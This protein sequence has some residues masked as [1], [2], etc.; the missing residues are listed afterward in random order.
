MLRTR[1]V[2][3]KGIIIN[4]VALL[5]GFTIWRVLFNNYAREVFDISAAEIGIIQAVREVP[6]LLGFTV[7][8]IALALSEVHIVTLSIAITGAGLVV[9]GLANSIL[10]LGAGT[11]LMSV[12]FHNVMTA[13]YS[14]LLLFV[15][16]PESGRKQGEL[17][18]WE[19]VAAVSA[20]FLVFLTSLT[21]GYR[22]I[23]ISTGLA[24]IVAGI[25][26]TLLYT[27]NRVGGEARSFRVD[28]RYW[29]YY[30]IS[31]L[32]GCRRHI[33]TTFAIFLMVANHGLRI[34]YTALLFLATSTLTIYTNRKF[35]SVTEILGERRVLVYTS[36]M[37]V[38]IFTGYAFITEINLLIGLF[39]I[40]N[41]LFGSG[42]ALDSYIR[43]VAATKDLTS[44]MSF[45][46]TANHITA[47]IVPIVGG[48]IWDTFGYRNTFL[49]GTAFVVADVCF[50]LLVNPKKQTVKTPIPF[51]EEPEG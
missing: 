15:K 51:Y 27:G 21:L 38:F 40:D 47:V 2:D 8:L 26:L 25:I 33:F 3:F 16:G 34:E 18:S 13:N 19:S 7:G 37:L 6:G 4:S 44:C 1:R 36:L 30:V 45:G 20:T 46:Q 50:G 24:L 31:F 39:V 12:G 35:G 5:F 10:M 11:L 22:I 41:A 28:R 17:R 48:I 32:R 43:K 42:V 14:L 29:L 23:L 49:L 9:A